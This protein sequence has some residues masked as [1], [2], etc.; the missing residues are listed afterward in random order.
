M[1]M[2][3][4]I[5][6]GAEALI[7]VLEDNDVDVIFGYPGGAILPVYDALFQN[8]KIRDPYNYDLGFS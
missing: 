2:S 5:M 7:K 6:N 8:K 1:K 4:K 3:K